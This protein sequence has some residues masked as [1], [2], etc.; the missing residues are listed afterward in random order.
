MFS[1]FTCLT[2]SESPEM[3]VPHVPKLAGPFDH[4]AFDVVDDEEVAELLGQSPPE[5]E[6][7]AKF[8]EEVPH[9]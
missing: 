5:G 1:S 9:A 3:P 4:S 2:T 8:D 6:A 7:A